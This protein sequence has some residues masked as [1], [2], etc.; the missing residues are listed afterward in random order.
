MCANL[1]L[2]F[3]L[4]SA[5][6]ARLYRRPALG[7]E[8]PRVCQLRGRDNFIVN[9]RVSAFLGTSR[10]LSRPLRVVLDSDAANAEPRE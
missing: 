9:D 1:I 7:R 5:H 10:V 3:R 8:G 6:R 4:V 2:L